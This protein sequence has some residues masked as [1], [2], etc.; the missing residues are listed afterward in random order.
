VA[1]QLV[2][3]TAG[4][5]DHGKTA[6]IRA[7]TGVDTDRLPQEK[8]RGITIELG[9]AP[10]ELP[11]GTRLGVIDVPGHEALVRTMVAGATGIDLVLLVVAADEGVMPQTREHAAICD[12]LGIS[13]GAVALTKCDVAPEDVR[14]LA[15]EEVADLL[16]DTSLAGA[17]IHEVSALT[18]AGLEDLRGALAVLASEA[19]AH[20]PRSGPPRLSI[21]RA[22]EMRGFGPVVTGTL[23]GSPLC[24]GDP[25]ELHPG[26]R[27][28]RVRGLQSF[29]QK[30]AEVAPGARSAVNLQ[31]VPL[32]DLHRGMVVT[33]PGALA[34]TLCFDAELTWLEEAQP[35][36]DSVAVELLAGTSERRA[37]VAPIGADAMVPGTHGFARIHVDGEPVALLPGDRFVLRGFSRTALGG[38]TIGGGRV[39]DVA[40]PRRRRSDP[41]LLAELERLTRA[42]DLTHVAVRIERAGYTSVQCEDLA[43]ETGIYRARVAELLGELE[44]SG[45]VVAL[46]AGAWCAA[47]NVARLETRLVETLRNFHAREPLRPGMP[48]STL[49]GTLPENAAPG[50]FEAILRRL[51]RTER[52]AARAEFVALPD[53]QPILDQEQELMAAH[54]R[55][56]AMAAA[57]EPPTLA[58]LTTELGADEAVLRDLLAYLERDGSLVRAPGDLWFDRVA[59]DEL[60]ERVVAH[61]REH[62]RLETTAYKA[63]IGTTRKWA[64]P[65]MELFDNEHLTTRRGDTRFPRRV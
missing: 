49:A 12:L 52:V 7:L 60:R 57:L 59:V 5:I 42:D 20:T 44:A 30:V 8:A 34:P 41:G 54:L 27:R 24:V 39:L 65:L 29:G 64:V 16:K 23:L 18:G 61:L 19:S 14:Q 17:T 10:L 55:A 37:R 13:H 51:E 31:G 21:D 1:E 33:A 62:G 32:S 2:L 47:G 43:R 40:P 50:L 6:L 11:G 58:E 22:F 3:G 56:T 38:S 63:M 15:A 36:G 25:V 46:A 26:T 35:G 9:F 48:R 53:H 28:A 4:H 45:T